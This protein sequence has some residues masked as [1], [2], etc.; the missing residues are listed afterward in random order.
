MSLVSVVSPVYHNAS[1]LPALLLEFKAVADRNPDDDFEFIF[2]EDGSRD[3]SLDVLVE[4]A[5]Q[6]PR[7]RVIKLSRNFGSNA[8]VLAGLSHARG[9]AVTVIAADLQDPPALLH[10]M[11]SHWRAGHKVVLAVRTGRGDPLVT[12]W[13]ASAFYALFRKFALPS[14]PRR[15]FDFFLMDCQ[16]CELIN[17]IQESNASIVGLVLWLGFD[18]VMIGYERRAREARYGRSMWTFT[19]KIKFFADS[20]VA[21]SYSPLRLASGLGITLSIVGLLYAVVVLIGRLLTKTE[22]SGYASLMVVVLVASG[23]QLFMIG[24]LGEYIWRNLEETRRRPRFI[25]DQVIR[26]REATEHRSES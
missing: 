11:L 19:R 20:F 1:S 4:L 6:D 26:G 7:V 10:D 9:D 13:F 16:V 18:P 22:P 12:R 15:G 17:G 23:T 24:I 3:N 14:M 21:F 2:V 8:A 5:D 25:V